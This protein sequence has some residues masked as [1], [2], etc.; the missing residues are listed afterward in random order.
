MYSQC[1]VLQCKT[2]GV[3]NPLD[4]LLQRSRGDSNPRNPYELN[5]FRNRLLQPLGHRSNKCNTSRC[6]MQLPHPTFVDSF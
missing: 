2:P 5:G 4:F 1:G 3:K 6:K